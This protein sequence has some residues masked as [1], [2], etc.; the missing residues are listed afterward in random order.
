MRLL[1]ATLLIA[2]ATLGACTSVVEDGGGT[3][4]RISRRAEI[5]V[6]DQSNASRDGFTIAGTLIASSDSEPILLVD[7]W[8]PLGGNDFARLQWRRWVKGDLSDRTVELAYGDA[9]VTVFVQVEND[10]LSMTS[11][12]TY[13]NGRAF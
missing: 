10:N 13:P 1:T 9:V 11:E 4:R 2:V 7:I 12:V 5:H 6:V 3:E 8:P